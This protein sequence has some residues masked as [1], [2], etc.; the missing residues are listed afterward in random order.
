MIKKGLPFLLL[1]LF[2]TYLGLLLEFPLKRRG[3]WF[4]FSSATVSTYTV[5]HILKKEKNYSIEFLFSLALLIEGS[6]HAFAIPWLRMAYFP[7]MVYITAFYGQKTVI[8]L[9]LLI[10][11]LGLG[12]FINGERLIEEIIFILS[13]A[14]T[15]G[16]SLFLKDKMKKTNM[17]YGS[18]NNPPNP[19]YTSLW[20]RGAGGEFKG[21]RDGWIR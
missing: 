5:L 8:S 14:A 18:K 15:A 17:L 16:I 2:L 6:V 3:L 13:L 20:K 4:L 1:L 19:P 10:P 12:N 9:L 7:F 21:G 11:F